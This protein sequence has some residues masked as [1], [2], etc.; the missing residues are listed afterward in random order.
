MFPM[1]LMFPALPK[2]RLIACVPPPAAAPQ[3]GTRRS[4]GRPH[5]PKGSEGNE[6]PGPG[7]WDDGNQGLL[8]EAQRQSRGGRG[9]SIGEKRSNLD[10]R[11]CSHVS[12]IYFRQIFVIK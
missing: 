10:G 12:G 2:D 9:G 7:T 1:V 5:Q 4:R 3:E 8:E 6:M 11:I